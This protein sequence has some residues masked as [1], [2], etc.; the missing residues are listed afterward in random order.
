MLMI[1]AAAL[2]VTATPL[3]APQAAPG[4]DGSGNG[5]VTADE[6]PVCRSIRVT[7]S[8]FP[9]R[10]CHTRAEWKSIHERDEANASRALDNRGSRNAHGE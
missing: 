1:L 10:E 5:A 3:V 7:G 6:K 9:K 2:A 8:N 4:A